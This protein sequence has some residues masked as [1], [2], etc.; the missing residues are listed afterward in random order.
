LIFC[1]IYNLIIYNLIVNNLTIIVKNISPLQQANKKMFNIHCCL[2]QPK[3]DNVVNIENLEDKEGCIL[4]TQGINLLVNK[5]KDFGPFEKLTDVQKELIKLISLYRFSMLNKYENNLVCPI[6]IVMYN[7]NMHKLMDWGDYKITLTL[8]NIVK[9]ITNFLNKNAENIDNNE[10]K[11]LDIAIYALTVFILPEKFYIEMFKIVIKN[12]L[13]YVVDLLL[14]CTSELYNNMY[15]NL[16]INKKSIVDVV[17]CEIFESLVYCNDTQK[18]K[19]I[20]IVEKIINLDHNNYI[21]KIEHYVDSLIENDLYITIQQTL[22]YILEYI[23]DAYTVHNMYHP[24]IDKKYSLKSKK[25][26][27][28]Q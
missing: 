13:F 11:I 24:G 22:L 8:I 7:C 4:Y 2:E 9:I 27:I 25:G 5:F 17:L 28:T 20:D 10:K 6:D 14:S 15:I 12:K 26:V 19:C 21:Y 23:D 18:I 1:I 3:R 16:Y